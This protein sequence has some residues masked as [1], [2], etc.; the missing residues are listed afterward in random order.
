MNGDE[1]ATDVARRETVTDAALR[2]FALLVDRAVAGELVGYG[3]LA[4]AA[5][6]ST[7]QLYAAL[8]E[9][10]DLCHDR[11][12]PLLNALAIN[13]RSGRPGAGFVPPDLGKLR[14]AAR[15]ALFEEQAAAAMAF[16]GWATLLAGVEPADEDLAQD[17]GEEQ[18]GYFEG[19]AV[20]RAH[21]D[22]ERS[23][24]VLAKARAYWSAVGLMR[25]EACGF[26]FEATYG[27][28]GANFIEAH[29]RVPLASLP[30]TGATTYQRDL[31]PVC[32]NC[33]R[34]IHRKDQPLTVEEVAALVRGQADRP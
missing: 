19:R 24:G 6:L 25:C 7:G 33:H 15:A 3:E 16:G 29:H 27:P 11:G 17:V 13:V 32:A 28:Q 9:L 26:D 23:Q 12:L 14:P 8:G 30:P 1:R 2:V 22:R 31:A 4:S 21:Y 10:R 18:E 34:M 20:L 5:G